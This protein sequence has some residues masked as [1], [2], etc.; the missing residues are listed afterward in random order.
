MRNHLPMFVICFAL[1]GCGSHSEGGMSGPTISSRVGKQDVSGL[2]SSDIMDR[3]RQT[4]RSK[5]RHVLIGWRDLEGAYGGRMDA[6]AKKRSRRDAER[7]TRAVFKRATSGTRFLNLMATYSEDRGSNMNGQAY[8]V[9]PGAKF[10][11]PFVRMG[12]RLKVGEVGIVQ[13]Q[14]GWHIMKRLE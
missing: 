11:K 12:L 2:Q 13:T 14:F 8:V 7:A 5:V 4:K 10:A 1:V 3:S 9:T 6:R